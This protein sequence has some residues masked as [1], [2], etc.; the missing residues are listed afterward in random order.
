MLT[1][2][3]DS[4]GLGNAIRSLLLNPALRAGLSANC[5][6]VAVEEYSPAVQAQRYLDLYRSLTG[7]D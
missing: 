6:R 1:P 5:R 3:R 2:L 7:K 4:A